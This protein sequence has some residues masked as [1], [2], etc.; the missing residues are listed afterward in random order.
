MNHIL[1]IIIITFIC[2]FNLYAEDKKV[3][4]ILSWEGFFSPELIADFSRKHNIKVEIIPYYSEEMRDVIFKNDVRKNIDLIVSTQT[5]T[6]D[7][8]NNGFLVPLEFEKLPNYKYMD[9]DYTL[10]RLVKIHAITYSYAVLGIAYRTDKKFDVPKSW[11]DFIEPHDNL[12]GRISLIDDADDSLDIFLMGAGNSLRSY[13]IEDLY[14][15]A[16]LL[17]YFKDYIY[18]FGYNTREEKEDPLM[19]GR[20]WMAPVYGF[21]YNDMIKDTDKLGFVFPSDA[22]KMWRDNIS[23]TIHSKNKGLSFDFLNYIMNPEIAA[24]Q[25]VYNTYSTLNS[26]A[27]KYIPE[28]IKANKYIYPDLDSL[29]IVTDEI[30]N[31]LIRNKKHYFYHRITRDNKGDKNETTE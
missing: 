7:Y 14:H 10:N 29:N 15:S 16:Q 28:D 13:S 20:V 1:K 19:S 21:E 18:E 26:E 23:V 4:R 5:G 11:S 22:T 17:N 3:L 30:D 31:V 8:I 12:K 25:F 24:K 6:I 27:E 9:T 2:S